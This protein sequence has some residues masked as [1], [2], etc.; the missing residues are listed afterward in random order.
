MFRKQT[1]RMI[2]A[3]AIAFLTVSAA[4]QSELLIQG[5]VDFGKTKNFKLLNGPEGPVELT[6]DFL[7]GGVDAH[8]FTSGPYIGASAGRGSTQSERHVNARTVDLGELSLQGSTKWLSVAFGWRV[9][10]SAFVPFVEATRDVTES[11][12]RMVD[13]GAQVRG[14]EP[15]TS[16]TSYAL[17]GWYELNDNLRVIGRLGGIGDGVSSYGAGVQSSL[18]IFSFSL[19]VA[20]S[21]E[22]SSSA[23]RLGV[24]ASIR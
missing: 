5:F 17:G 13:T 18:G 20:H 2:V 4:A 7:S 8:Q 10:D 6:N 9:P 21:P 22:V 14:Y 3:S 15:K 23:V 16:D 11:V 19:G 1:T 24:G 12:W